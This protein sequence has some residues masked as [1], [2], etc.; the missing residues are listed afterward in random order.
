MLQCLKCPRNTELSLV[1]TTDEHIA[2]LNQAY[3][4]HVGPTNVIS[5]SQMEGEGPDNG[6][7]GDVVVSADTAIAEAR[8]NGLDET[9]HFYRLILHGTL[10]LLGY[11]HEDGGE[12]ARIMEELT[13]EVLEN[14][15]E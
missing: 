2:E 6:V 10:H 9:E 4:G 15:R 11:H 13:E 8:A 1:F 7:L 12:D 5:F 3:L 14:S